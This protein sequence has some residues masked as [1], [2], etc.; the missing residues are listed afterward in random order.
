MPGQ[1]SFDWDSLQFCAMN[2]NFIIIIIT[3]TILYT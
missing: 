1:N 3:I 2:V